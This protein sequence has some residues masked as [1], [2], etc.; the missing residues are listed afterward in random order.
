[1]EDRDSGLFLH[2]FDDLNL[3]SGYGSVGREILEDVPD[4]DVVLVCCGGG[5]LVAGVAAAIKAYWYLLCLNTVCV[6]T[7]QECAFKQ[8]KIRLL[9][10]ITRH[11]GT[12]KVHGKAAFG[13][14][15][16]IHILFSV[17]TL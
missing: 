14:Y 10:L 4:V 5:G 6:F 1:M 11:S 8:I 9:I 2:P 17:I 7:T 15:H 3:I 13:I 16:V 12:K